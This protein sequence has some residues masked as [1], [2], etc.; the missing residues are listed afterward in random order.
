MS[1][2]FKEDHMVIRKD[3]PGGYAEL[4][5]TGKIPIDQLA[6]GTPSG[7]KF[8]RDDRTLQEISGVAGQMGPPGI[9]GEDG[10]NAWPIPGRDGA[11][12]AAGSPGA[13]GAQGLMGIPGQDGEDCGEN[14]PIPVNGLLPNSSF[15]GLGK[16]SVGTTAPSNPSVGDL[17]VDCS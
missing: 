10:E 6:Y 17:W 2:S 3:V 13:T 9:E 5:E 12:G 4:D 8:I 11:Q 16:I 14:W 7:T 1:H 15:S